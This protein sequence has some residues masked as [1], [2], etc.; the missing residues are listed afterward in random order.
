MQLVSWNLN[1][2]EDHCLD[3]RTEA[4]MFQMLLG[5]PPE[6]VM[7]K[8]IKPNMPDIIVLQEVVE[9]SFYAHIKP[10][11]K[12]AGFHIYPE[13]P[14]ERS[15]FEVIA[16]REAFG[17]TQYQ[18][19]S[20]TE[21]GRGLSMARLKNGLCVMTAHMES[22][23]SGSA[24]RVDQAKEISALM[25]RHSPCVFAGDTNLRKKEWLSLD[26][27]GEKTELKTGIKDAW[28]ALGA[29]ESHKIT[30]KNRHYKARYDRVWTHALGTPTS[31]ETFGKDE[32]AGIQ[33]PVS[34]H[35]ALRVSFD[36]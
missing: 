14:A 5:A 15:Y 17:E 7:L 6:K 4:A 11:L 1:G 21:Q 31:F 12:A 25:T 16:S 24:M 29:P 28:E 34:D 8:G 35:Y 26:H 22:Q 27:T 32:I 18:R 36:F 19:F 13:A 23:K 20:W 33:M 30:W 2:L 3:E 10:H 9:R